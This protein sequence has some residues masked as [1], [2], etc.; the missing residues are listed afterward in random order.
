VDKKIMSI[1]N[2]HPGVFGSTL[3]IFDEFQRPGQRATVKAVE[4]VERALEKL[5]RQGKVEKDPARPHYWKAV[6]A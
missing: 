2:A 4:R 3:D 1:L 5:Q 6:G